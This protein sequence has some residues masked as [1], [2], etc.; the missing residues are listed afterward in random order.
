MLL[1]LAVKSC[2]P[3]DLMIL[4]VTENVLV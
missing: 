2:A 3:A 1:G 4:F